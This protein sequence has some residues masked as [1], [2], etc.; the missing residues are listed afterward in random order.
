MDSYGAHEKDVSNI[1]LQPQ[2]LSV[3]QS[4]PS[5]ER[6]LLSA[7]ALSSPTTANENTDDD[8]VLPGVDDIHFAT[9]CLEY[10]IGGSVVCWNGLNSVLEDME[11]LAQAAS[12]GLAACT[13]FVGTDSTAKFVV[14]SIQ[15]M[16]IGNLFHKFYTL[17]KKLTV[18]QE[19]RK[20]VLKQQNQLNL[21]NDL[22]P[23]SALLING[24]DAAHNKDV[25]ATEAL[26]D[27]Y[28]CCAVSRTILVDQVGVLSIFCQCMAGSILNYCQIL[29]ANERS[30]YLLMGT[31]FGVGATVL[32]AYTKVLIKKTKDWEVKAINAMSYVKYQ[33]RIAARENMV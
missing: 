12:T 6:S 18:I 3:V 17:S 13:Q 29:D 7:H 25:Y 27:Y 33:K 30:G 8:S 2:A 5:E 15:L 31:L 32:H 26:A 16:M 23:R 22:D 10:Y 21:E 4:P 9:P 19:K 1:Q 20:L 14:Y 28:S 24:V 11:I